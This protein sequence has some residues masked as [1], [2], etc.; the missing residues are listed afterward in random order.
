MYPL[1]YNTLTRRMPRGTME[2]TLLEYAHCGKTV[3][4]TGLS[5]PDEP[6]RVWVEGESYGTCPLEET[7]PFTRQQASA[8]ND[9]DAIAAATASSG[10]S[11]SAS[12]KGMFD[13]EFP[14][15]LGT[16]NGSA[17]SVQDMLAAA[18][19]ITNLQAMLSPAA[20]AGSMGPF[21]ALS[22][23]TD[24]DQLKTAFIS[25]ALNGTAQAAKS[26]L[27]LNETFVDSEVKMMESLIVGDALAHHMEPLYYAALASAFTKAKKLAQSK[28]KEA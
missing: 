17:A 25:G 7:N 24:L 8:T 13:F 4:L 9:A 21:G 16:I 5:D 20:S 10:A 18:S 12:A 27:G 19:N 6:F 3:L 23:Q 22:V 1:L 14:V 11:S 26:V 28:S 2:P 15:S